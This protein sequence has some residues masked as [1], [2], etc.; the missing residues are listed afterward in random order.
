M[1]LIVAEFDFSYILLSAA[2][3]R[4]RGKHRPERSNP[5]ESN[6]IKPLNRPGIT[7]ENLKLKTQREAQAGLWA[8]I[9]VRNNAALFSFASQ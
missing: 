8:S 4:A 3:A 5:T 7:S 6:Q 1:L 2:K 9:S